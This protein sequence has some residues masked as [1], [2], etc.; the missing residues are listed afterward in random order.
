MTHDEIL[1]DWKAKSPR[2]QNALVAEKVF[3]V[4]FWLEQ[5]G[6]YRMAVTSRKD[7]SEPWKDTKDGTDE[8][9][10]PVSGAKA[11]EAG[12]FGTGVKDYVGTYEGMGLVIA[13]MRKK[14]WSLVM[15]IG[16]AGIDMER[17]ASATWVRWREGS[18][19][20]GGPCE[21][22]AA[23]EAVALAALKA[24]ETEK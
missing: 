14:G 12:F 17:E 9:Y 22:D 16:T 15:E 18:Q 8:R 24:V 3:A 1:A 23:P 13:E 21:A 6:Q 20:S 19:E 5:R 11:T 2:E 7:G 4:R 10:T